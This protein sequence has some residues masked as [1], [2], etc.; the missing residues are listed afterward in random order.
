MESKVGRL[1]P[2]LLH[3]GLQTALKLLI[4]LKQNDIRSGLRIE[5]RGFGRNVATD[6]P[7]RVCLAHA[8]AVCKNNLHP[9][10]R[11]NACLGLT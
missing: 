9:L 4:S 6:L 8:I 10:R 3:S 7:C 5:M 1:M 11:P 2:S